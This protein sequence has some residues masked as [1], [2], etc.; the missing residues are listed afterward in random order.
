MVGRRPAVV[1]GAL[2][3]AGA[4]SPFGSAAAPGGPEDGG[5]AEGGPTGP[6]ADA[7]SAD[8]A[9]ADAPDA[10][11]A[12][13][14]SHFLCEDFDGPFPWTGWT[15]MSR[16]GS[17][18]KRDT[19]L[20]VSPPAS[21]H[22]TIQ[23]ASDSDHPSYL[24]RDLPAAQRI[25]VSADVVVSRSTGTPPNGEIDVVA[26]ELA[27]PIGFSRYFVTIVANADGE[28]ILETDVVPQ[29]GGNHSHREKLGNLTSGFARLQLALDLAVG[30]VTGE[31]GGVSKTLQLVSA[32]G[33]GASLKI[34]VAWANNSSGRFAVNIDNLIVDQ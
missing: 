14:A 6:D 19:L 12:C 3:V 28:Y 23:P 21:L 17:E 2:V 31:A 9:S 8:G 26:L 24:R 27:P 25:D 20:F 5:L 7:G 13:A 22:V 33:K 10:R 32:T 29:S 15:D 4:C 16:A 18:I 34:G 1:L 30:N 11:S